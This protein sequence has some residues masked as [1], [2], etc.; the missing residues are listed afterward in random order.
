MGVRRSIG[1]P[2]SAQRAAL[3]CGALAGLAGLAAAFIAQH[4]AIRPNAMINLAVDDPLATLVRAE[5]PRFPLVTDVQHYDGVYY[6]AIARDPLLSGRAHTLIDQPAYRYGHPLHGWLAG[7][8]TLGHPAAIPTALFTLSLSGLF[9]TGWL[10]SRL[11]HSLGGTP[12][13]GLL[14]AG[15][16]GLL[17]S[18]TVST[19]EAA[20]AAL[21][22]GALLAW[23]HGRLGLAGVVM[24]AGCLDK[25][26]YLAVPIGLALWELTQRRTRTPTRTWPATSALPARAA[27]VLLA[28]IPLAAWYLFVH[29]RLHHWPFDYQPGN[30]GWPVQGWLQTFTYAYALSTGSFEQSEIGTITI[31]VLVAI[32][33]ILLTATA[34]ALWFRSSPLHLPLTLLAVITACQGWRT[35]LYPHEIVRTPAV[36]LLL[37]ALVLLTPP[38]PAPGTPSADV[39]GLADALPPRASDATDRPPHNSP[40]R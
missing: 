25:E 14:A 15:S 32:A 35:L 11:A 8:L 24:A 29:A 5:E 22:I 31:P 38:R 3:V 33:M 37:A 40:L 17:Y 26:Q 10:T 30:L 34:R 13:L 16:P 27:A 19:T 4:G 7:L 2:S 12:W 28:P 1:R 6:Y 18:V 20:G 39:S 23:H 9:A 36:V 21:V